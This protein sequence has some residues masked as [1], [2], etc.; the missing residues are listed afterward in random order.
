MD[1]KIQ[2]PSIIITSS[3][4]TGTEYF[5]WLL[6]KV[7]PDCTAFHEPQ[8]ITHINSVNA[9][10]ETI[11]NF[12]ILNATINKFRGKWGIMALSNDRVSGLITDD[13]AIQRLYNERQQFI[14]STPGSIYGESSYH[15]FGITDLIPHVFAN[16]RLIYILRDGR[17]WA[18]SI[19]NY[20]RLYNWHDI[21]SIFG[22]RLTPGKNDPE[23]HSTWHKISRFEKVCWYWT[24]VTKTAVRA[25]RAI[26]HA[27]VYKYEDVFLSENKY[28]KL[29]E[30]LMFATSF[31]DQRISLRS[32][33]G[34]LEKRL[35]TRRSRKFPEWQNW[36]QEQRDQ[37]TRICG[38][39]MQECGYSLD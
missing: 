5:S 27:R 19:M 1:K 13:E 34:V 16:Y 4:R 7:V 35:N 2:K 3:G 31:D 12:G 24:I 6:N 9:A 10:A 26:D 28:E 39:T 15:Y 37:F 36:S 23:F 17:A 32:I 21:Y 22:S 14:I 29:R 20:N 25:S 30:L 38:P 11:K 33:D 8:N 18:R